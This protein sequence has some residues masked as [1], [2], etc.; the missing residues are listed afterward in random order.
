M[1][2]AN[3]T[4]HAILIAGCALMMAPVGLLILAPM[5]FGTGDGLRDVFSVYEQVL[6]AEDLFSNG[7]NASEM[8]I[9][10]LIVAGG[11]ALL[12][13]VFSLLAAYALVCFRLPRPELLLLGLLLP[14]FFP[15]ETRILPTFLVTNN[16]GLLNTYTGMILPIVASGLGT[17]IFRQVILQLPEDVFEAARIDGAGP[18]KTFRDIVIPLCFPMTGALFILIFVIGWNQYL[19]PL[20]ITTTSE[21]H[22]TIVRGIE[23]AGV[24][25]RAGMALAVFAMLPPVALMLLAQRRI[26]RGLASTLQ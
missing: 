11:I 24:A 20:M 3:F 10:S 1:K 19:W 15:I 16:L 2:A 4:D 8:L 18:F 26:M 23:R 21:E 17:L 9:N 25:G 13:T 22:Y 5:S 7:V 6:F 12:S 14:L